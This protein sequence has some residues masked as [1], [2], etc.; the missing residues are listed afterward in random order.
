[1]SK[2][3]NQPL[4]VTKSLDDCKLCPIQVVV[5]AR[6]AVTFLI[7][8]RPLNEREILDGSANVLTFPSAREI[9][10]NIK[11][12]REEKKYM[13]DRVYPPATPQEEIYLNTVSPIIEEV[14]KGFN[15]T[16]FAYGQTGTGKTFT[17]EG[18]RELDNSTG[19]SQLHKDAGIIPRS[20][21]QIFD[22]LES[23][24]TEYVVK[25]SFLEIYNE[26][27]V[28]LLAP[29][30]SDSS[31]LKI[32]DDITRKGMTTVSGL[33]EVPVTN[34]RDI[35]QVLDKGLKHRQTAETNLNKHSRQ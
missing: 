33:Q 5:R 15:C 4:K 32:F 9:T 3:T 22:T 13:Y 23:S 2:P 30:S 31:N 11:V 7:N 19:V 6:Y 8:N 27:L 25:V 14:L 24:A 16:I 12:K 21:K 17:M 29:P 1:M 26:E 35:F 28:D 10:A 20:V 34:S 18:C